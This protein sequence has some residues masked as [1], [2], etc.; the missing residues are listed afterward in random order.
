MELI[1][2]GGEIKPGSSS[3][4]RSLTG[5]K[6]SLSMDGVGADGTAVSKNVYDNNHRLGSP[7][8]SSYAWAHNSK[9]DVEHLMQQHK[10][11]S[12]FASRRPSQATDAQASLVMKPTYKLGGGY[13]NKSQAASIAQTVPEGS[14]SGGERNSSG[15]KNSGSGGTGNKSKA[16]G[17]GSLKSLNS[18]VQPITGA[19]GEVT[20]L[21]SGMDKFLVPPPTIIASRDKPQLG[22][23]MLYQNHGAKS[24][25]NTYV[26]GHT[27]G[28]KSM[29]MKSFG[30]S[31]F[32]NASPAKNLAGAS[33]VTT[34]VA[35][36]RTGPMNTEKRGSFGSSISGGG[37][38]TLKGGTMARSASEHA[39]KDHGVRSSGFTHVMHDNVLPARKTTFHPVSMLKPSKGRN[40]Q[41]GLQKD[42]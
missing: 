26:T 9:E 27:M 3:G 38:A 7:V 18:G 1:N 28:A 24:E 25:A 19:N 39:H 11:V 36:S 14:G 16:S 41:R 2:N 30:A 10:S 32:H 31:T 40:A 35:R 21:L 6:V 13:G 12:A 22:E 5:T 29:S 17:S 20:G 37:G 8:R 4:N 23:T 15:L 34:N 42:Y 33:S